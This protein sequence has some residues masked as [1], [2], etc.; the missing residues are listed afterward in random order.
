MF[1]K[2]LCITCFCL[3]SYWNV[4][5]GRLFVWQCTRNQCFQKHLTS[6]KKWNLKWMSKTNHTYCLTDNEYFTKYIFDASVNA[7]FVRPRISSHIGPWLRSLLS[8]MGLSLCLYTVPSI[9]LGRI[10]FDWYCFIYC[11]IIYIWRKLY[12]LAC[13]IVLYFCGKAGQC[14][15]ARWFFH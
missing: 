13:Y 12:T 2:H 3:L 9:H 1:R 5:T 4:I 6:Y 11:K 14:F 7:I 10:Q 8:E 15:H